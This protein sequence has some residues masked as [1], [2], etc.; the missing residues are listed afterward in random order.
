MHVSMNTP[1]PFLFMAGRNRFLKPFLHSDIFSSSWAV[2]LDGGHGA[3][4]HPRHLIPTIYWR[5]HMSMS[6][7]MTN[8]CVFTKGRRKGPSKHF[9][10]SFGYFWRQSLLAC[11]AAVEPHKA[12]ALIHFFY[13]GYSPLSGTS[14]K[15]PASG[16]PI[17]FSSL[18]PYLGISSFAT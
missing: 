13:Q 6:L 10:P 17:T 4:G 8:N 16:K 5:L 9:Y 11:P 14:R 2:Q 1:F 15:K 12:S 7:F 18:R 3:G